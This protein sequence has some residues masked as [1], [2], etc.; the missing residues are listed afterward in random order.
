MIIAYNYFKNNHLSIEVMKKINGIVNFREDIPGIFN[1][2]FIFKS[3]LD[4][5]KIALDTDEILPP[6]EILIHPSGICNL[7]CEWCI[8]ANVPTKRKSTDNNLKALPTKLTDPQKMEE[9][10]R[11]ILSYKKTVKIGEGNKE[12]EFKVERVQFSGIVGEPLVAKE[13]I[14]R[15]VRILVAEDIKVGIFTNATLIDDELIPLLLEMSYINISLDA[16]TPATYAK[17]KYG[18]CKQGEALFRKVLKNIEKLVVAREKSESSQL[19]INAS[20]VLYPGNYK[21]IYKAAQSLKRLGIDTLRMKQD[22][23]AKNLLSESEIQDADYYI[24]KVEQL[25]DDNFDFV[26]IHRLNDPS[27]MK[28]I[29]KQCIVTELMGAIGCDGNVYPCNYHPRVGGLSYGDALVESFEKIW[30]GRKRCEL[31]KLIPD[32]CPAVC[33]PFKN[34]ANRLFGEIYEFKR[35]NGELE[36]DRLLRQLAISVED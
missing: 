10:I 34:R 36:T 6:Y 32:A 17:M 12:K 35:K 2:A 33:D 30:E 19:K 18:G 4:R 9:I 20:F 11:N 13:S 31:K 1:E 16:G 21:D 28:R 3:Q 26:K 27:E 22:N 25:M 23:S 24:N 29:H 7:K 15:A 5:F 8:G 14:K